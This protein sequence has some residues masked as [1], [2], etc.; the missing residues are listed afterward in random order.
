MKTKK[1]AALLSLAALSM[2]FSYNVDAA[3][4]ISPNPED[5]KGICRSNS[6]GGSDCIYTSGSGPK[7]NGLVIIIKPPTIEE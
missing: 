5:N 3:C 4:G 6:E 7:C 1:L 2:T